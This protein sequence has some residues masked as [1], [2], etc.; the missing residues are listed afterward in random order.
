M[1][2]PTG[3]EIDQNQFPTED[4]SATPYSPC[5]KDVPSNSSTPRGMCFN[6]RTFVDSDHVGDSVTRRSRTGFI[7]SS[8]AVLFFIQRNRGVVRHQVFGS[9]F[10][11]MKSCCEYLRGLRCTLRMFV[12]LVEYPAC[13]FGGNQSFY[14][15]PQNLILI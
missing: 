4:W 11:V 2:D 3:P 10:I 12:I 14:P 9:E 6:M 15:I 8:T 7:V 13:V 5:N 1:F